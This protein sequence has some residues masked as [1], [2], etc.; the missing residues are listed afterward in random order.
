VPHEN[1][2]GLQIWLLGGVVEA[3]HQKASDRGMPLEDVLVGSGEVIDDLQGFVVPAGS[4][5]LEAGR[6]LANTART[7]SVV[8][9]M[10]DDLVRLGLLEKRGLQFSLTPEG[11]ML[12]ERLEVV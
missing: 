10:L 8:S 5:E 11:H 2:T 12:S 3:L 1:L 4:A 7:R 6:T 9:R